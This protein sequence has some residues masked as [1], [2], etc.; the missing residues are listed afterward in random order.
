MAET[1]NGLVLGPDGKLHVGKKPVEKNPTASI[2]VDGQGTV[3][4]VPV[5]EQPIKPVYNRLNGKLELPLDALIVD[6]HG[7]TKG[8]K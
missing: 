7:N 8:K 1:T 5:I 2:I 6:A 4:Q 3:S